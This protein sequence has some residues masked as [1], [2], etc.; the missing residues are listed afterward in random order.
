MS[1]VN[2]SG[3]NE[4]LQATEYLKQI[5]DEMNQDLAHIGTA[6]VSVDPKTV[7]HYQ[8]RLNFVAALFDKMATQPGQEE[9]KDLKGL[10]LARPLN[11]QMKTKA[12]E[13][14]QLANQIGEI[15]AKSTGKELSLSTED[16]SKMVVGDD[17]QQ[18]ITF[19]ASG[20]QQS[21]EIDNFFN[22]LDQFSEHLD[23]VENSLNQAS[24][25]SDATGASGEGKTRRRAQ[26]PDVA[27]QLATLATKSR[28]TSDGEEAFSDSIAQFFD[29]IQDKIDD[30]DDA[31]ETEFKRRR[32]KLSDAL[33]KA[34]QAATNESV[35]HDRK[36]GEV[37]DAL[38]DM[39]DIMSKITV[40]EET[41]NAKGDVDVKS[42]LAGKSF[43]T[44]GK[45]SGS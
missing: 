34:S 25:K 6:K 41:V 42:V 44:S 23:R 35:S 40:T 30:Q 21:Q 39:V 43:I 5:Q 45:Q 1:G 18:D 12:A 15:Y 16:Y 36:L 32:A 4:A 28:E 9:S 27:S 26:L 19:D 37:E 33:D 38:T 13:A 3:G 17:Y 31:T 14:R 20:A 8:H 10:D 11:M 22:S 29:D 24:G 2:A 7:E